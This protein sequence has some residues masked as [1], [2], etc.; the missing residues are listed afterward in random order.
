[1]AIPG[2]RKSL[3]ASRPSLR[4]CLVYSIFHFTMHNAVSRSPTRCTVVRL[5]QSFIWLYNCQ[6][7]L[8]SVGNCRANCRRPIYP[9]TLS[10]PCKHQT[11]LIF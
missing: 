5:D 8:S 1:M 9:T 6:W 4:Y 2:S 11:L 3:A 10:S 7:Y